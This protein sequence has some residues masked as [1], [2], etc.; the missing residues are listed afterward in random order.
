MFVPSLA[1]A[2]GKRACFGYEDGSVRVWDLKM[3]NLI[4]FHK[5]PLSN[6]S[7]AVTSLTSDRD[8]SIVIAGYESG[9]VKVINS[10]GGQVCCI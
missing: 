9:S 4:S 1:I 7:A 10:S 8:G 3:S 6:Q 5:P 2:T